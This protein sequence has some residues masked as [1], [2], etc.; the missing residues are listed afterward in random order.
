[1][2]KFI[3]INDTN[4]INIDYI[5]GLYVINESCYRLY[6]R[7]DY[8]NLSKEDFNRISKILLEAKNE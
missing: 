1:M 8:I 4:I 6:T 2:A 3:K 5:I 7:N